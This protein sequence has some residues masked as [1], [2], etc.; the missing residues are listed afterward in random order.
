MRVRGLA[1]VAMAAIVFGAC[2][3]TPGASTA[4]SAAPTSAATAAPSAAPP[5]AAPST[6][7][8]GGAAS[9]QLTYTIMNDFPSCFHPICFQTGGQFGV[10]EML[11]SGL[12]KR[13]PTEK[14]IPSLAE[15]WEASPDATVFTFHL[16]RKSTRLNSSH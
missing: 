8:S 3:S 9:G 14:I 1:F 12:V 11:Y 16:D 15:S 2:S 5:S 7:P 13:D 4:P 6:A 10:F